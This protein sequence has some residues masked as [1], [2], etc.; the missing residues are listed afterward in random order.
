MKISQLITCIIL[1]VLVMALGGVYLGSRYL[2]LNEFNELE[3][4]SMERNLMRMNQAYLSELEQLDTLTRDWA[5]WDD[6]YHYMDKRDKSYEAN[7]LNTLTFETL[8]VDSILYFRSD[9]QYY[10]GASLIN[11]AS[12]AVKNELIDHLSRYVTASST[13]DVSSGL[14]NYNGIYYFLSKMPI[15]TSEGEGPINGY[16]VFLKRFDADVKNHLQK[17]VSVNA[18]FFRGSGLNE[19]GKLGILSKLHGKSSYVITEPDQIVGFAMLPAVGKQ[20]GIMVEIMQ[21]RDYFLQGQNMVKTF[22]LYLLFGGIVYLVI[23][24][25]TLNTF[26]SSRLRSLAT[27]LALIGTKG[28]KLGRVWVDGKDEIAEV[29]QACNSM[30]DTIETMYS[31]QE[32]SEQRQRKQSEALVSLAKSDLLLAGDLP[33]A[34]QRIN[35][36]IC[37]GSDATRS[38]IWYCSEDQQQM[39][40]PDLYFAPTDHHQQAPSLP[41]HFI[42]GRYESAKLN[43]SVVWVIQDPYE[44]SRFNAMIERLGLA[45][46]EGV[47]MISPIQHNQELFG[48]IIVEQERASEHWCQDE[49][50]F[51]ISICEYSAQ[52]LTALSKL[53]QHQEL[54]KLA[55]FDELTGMANRPHFL[56]LMKRQLLRAKQLDEL[57][58]FFFIG[59]ERLKEVNDQYGHASGDWV[60]TCVAERMKGCLRSSDQIGRSGGGEFMVYLASP[61]N[62]ED[63]EFVGAKLLAAIEAPI[64]FEGT[65]LAVSACIGISLFPS[66]SDDQDRL[67]HCAEMA[68]NHL[69]RNS[70][71]GVHLY[72]AGTDRD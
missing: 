64:D 54:E 46:L 8:K 66:Q 1:V 51:I 63:A 41:Y 39:F 65:T 37:R 31:A 49:E 27:N 30:L 71:R 45:P 17:A 50:I 69:R 43:S 48:F 52:T 72:D 35:E 14:W 70:E 20:V 33:R 25:F 59:V 13:P 21:P 32:E 68:M 26:V 15:L 58:A 67:I 18:K 47:V 61:R 28:D 38:S 56:R 24:L 4:E 22:F 7:N 53:Q 23:V 6:T 16:L 60:I 55:S 19:A 2:I 40:C 62:L 11:G 5:E 3:Q 34:A 9:K 42:R 10:Y 36:A 12:R 29:A 44:R 57:M